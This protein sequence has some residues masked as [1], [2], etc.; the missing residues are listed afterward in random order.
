MTMTELCA[1]LKNYFIRDTARDIHADTYKIE[2]G[3]ISPAPFLTEGDFFRIVGSRKNDGPGGCSYAARRYRL[4]GDCDGGC[5]E[6]SL[7]ERVVRRIHVFAQV[8]RRIKWVCR[9]SDVAGSLRGSA[10]T[11]S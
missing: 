5:S 11:L 4:L 8:F 1:E 7:S 2:N 3:S 9:G 10:E 6:Q